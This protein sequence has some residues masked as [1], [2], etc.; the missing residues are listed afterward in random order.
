ME[1]YS[2]Y[3]LL[4]DGSLTYCG[5][6]VPRPAIKPITKSGWWRLV[7]YHHIKNVVKKNKER[8]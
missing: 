5:Y 4:P 7:R 6:V 8:R 1:D 2:L 3:D